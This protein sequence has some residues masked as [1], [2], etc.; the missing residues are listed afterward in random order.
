MRVEHATLNMQRLQFIIHVDKTIN[1][2]GKLDYAVN[3][4]CFDEANTTLVEKF[5]RISAQSRCSLCQVIA[6]P[7]VQRSDLTLLWQ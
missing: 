7:W 6:L 1:T 4:A 5:C 2:Y 3:N